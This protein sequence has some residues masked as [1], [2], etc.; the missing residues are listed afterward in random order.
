MP[1]KKPPTKDAT[2]ERYGGSDTFTGRILE[3]V[4]RTG[5]DPVRQEQLAEAGSRALVYVSLFAELERFVERLRPVK[6]SG[7][8]PPAGVTA[9]DH[10]R[11]RGAVHVIRGAEPT[12][13]RPF[14]YR[15][16][17]ELVARYR[18]WMK[19]KPQQRDLANEWLSV[20]LMFRFEGVEFTRG[21]E[22]VKVGEAFDLLELEESDFDFL[23]RAT[24]AKHDEE[25]RAREGTAYLLLRAGLGQGSKRRPWTPEEIAADPGEVVS[26]AKDVGRYD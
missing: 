20:E 7:G 19:D 17:G 11:L 2:V 12:Y 18:A 16:C 8:V 14:V 4:E 9:E 1:K 15:Q 5:E 22:L 6:G 23:V 24:D 3:D 13:T 25:L 26:L 10:L 21:T